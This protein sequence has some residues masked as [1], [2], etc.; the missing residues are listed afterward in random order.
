MIWQEILPSY[1]A[2]LSPERAANPN[3]GDQLTTTKQNKKEVAGGGNKFLIVWEGAGGSMEVDFLL[4][5]NSC[6][7][8]N[9][10][11]KGKKDRKLSEPK[12]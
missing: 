6:I 5:P 10:E 12:K 4:R 1:Q 8:V 7:A 9:K 11:R 2:F 3:P